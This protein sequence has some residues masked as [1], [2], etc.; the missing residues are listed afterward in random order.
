MQKQKENY[1]RLYEEQLR[2][3]HV[4]MDYLIHKGLFEDCEKWKKEI[5]KDESVMNF[6]KGK[7]E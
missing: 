3:K 5:E 7:N 4:I 6:L 1:K 2:K